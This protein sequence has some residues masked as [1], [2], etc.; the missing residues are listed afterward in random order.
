MQISY[1]LCH[2]CTQIDKHTHIHTR[3]QGCPFIRTHTGALAHPCAFIISHIIIYTLYL[4]AVV[5][6]DGGLQYIKL[7]TFVVSNLGQCI[8]LSPPPLEH[9]KL[10]IFG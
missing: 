1:S 7:L 9:K 6:S 8:P 4:S 2:T 10:E 5:A 3:T